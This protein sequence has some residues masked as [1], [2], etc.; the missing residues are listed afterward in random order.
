MAER[1]STCVHCRGRIVLSDNGQVWLH[2]DGLAWRRECPTTY[3]T[4]E[5]RHA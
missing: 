5:V 2:P 1:T 4:P 3:A